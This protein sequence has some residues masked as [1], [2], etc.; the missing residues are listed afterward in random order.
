[1]VE[2]RGEFAVQ[3]GGAFPFGEVGPG[4]AT[5]QPVKVHEVGESVG[6]GVSHV[7]HEPTALGVSEEHHRFVGDGV[8]HGKGVTLVGGP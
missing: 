2:P 5:R 8:E 6:D 1:M 4:V 3:H 7:Q